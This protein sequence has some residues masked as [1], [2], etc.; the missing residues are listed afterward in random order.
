MT[1]FAAAPRRSAFHSPHRASSSGRAKSAP[2]AASCRICCIRP[3]RSSCRPRAIWVPRPRAS[4][5]RTRSTRAPLAPLARLALTAPARGHL[6]RRAGTRVGGVARERGAAS[7][8][9][10]RGCIRTPGRGQ[11][12]TRQGTRGRAPGRLR[13]GCAI[14]ELRSEE[15]AVHAA[16][17]VA[18]TS[19]S[20]VPCW[21]CRCRSR[22]RCCRRC[23]SAPATRGCRSG[24]PS[25]LHVPLAEPMDPGAVQGLEAAFWS[26]DRERCGR[27]AGDGRLGL[28]GRR[29]RRCRPRACARQ[30]SLARG[31]AGAPARAATRGRG[32]SHALGGRA[33]QRRLVRLPPSRL[34]AAGRR[35]RRCAAWPRAS[36][37]RAH[38]GRVLRHVRGRT[39]QRRPRRRRGARGAL[40][41][42]RSVLTY[43]R[44]AIY[45]GGWL[46]GAGKARSTVRPRGRATG[47]AQRN[48]KPAPRSCGGAVQARHHPRQR[49]RAGPARRL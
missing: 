41:H 16:G 12:R 17:G 38:R 19:A 37:R 34:V 42:S 20:T 31:S 13:L 10:G 28:R 14:R 33:V 18:S 3:S 24:S 11:R 9:R 29:A 2:T 7:R 44:Y 4:R 26:L 43:V 23:A 21:P 39:A 27:R 6:H 22:S 32:G 49:R 1:I 46:T 48:R 30:R 47:R 35:G 40:P 8:R 15:D 36:R 45:T 25:K 5:R